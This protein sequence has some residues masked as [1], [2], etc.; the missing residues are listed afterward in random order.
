[1]EKE[2]DLERAK[3]LASGGRPDR[4]KQYQEKRHRV[5][6]G[7]K[8]QDSD[9]IEDIRDLRKMLNDAI[10][11][12]KID[13]WLFSYK[14]KFH[15]VQNN[16][17]KK[18]TEAEVS[19]QIDQFP[20]TKLFYLCTGKRICPMPDPFSGKEP[21]CVMLVDDDE[22]V[23]FIKTTTGVEISKSDL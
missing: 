17:Y 2:F 8:L 18:L 22:V 7:M 13:G 12:V 9:V 20:D 21:E 3:R 6:A 19:G 5:L 14:G 11:P 23:T 10:D 4:V 1:M 16:I 15:L